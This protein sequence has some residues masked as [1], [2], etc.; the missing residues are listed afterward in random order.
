V[1]SNRYIP[2]LI[3]HREKHSS[4]G[5]IIVSHTR[6][7]PDVLLFVLCVRACIRMCTSHARSLTALDMSSI[8]IGT[9]FHSNDGAIARMVPLCR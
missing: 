8:H 3:T 2:G 1:Y 6:E 9:I 5:L 7:A 4:F